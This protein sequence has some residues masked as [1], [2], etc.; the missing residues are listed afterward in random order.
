MRSFAGLL[1]TA[2]GTTRY[3]F[4]ARP[5]IGSK[6]FAVFAPAMV[7][8]SPN[9]TTTL[10]WYVPANM[11]PFRKSAGY[12]NI[13]RDVTLGSAGFAFSKATMSSGGDFFQASAVDYSRA[14]LDCSGHFVIEQAF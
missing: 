8:S 7:R 11:F 5:G 4:I 2:S 13:G 9:R 10:S 3:S 14:R 1:M 12:P 6:F